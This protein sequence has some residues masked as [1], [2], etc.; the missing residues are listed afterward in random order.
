MTGSC[1]KCGDSIASWN[2]SGACTK[3]WPSVR[4]HNPRDTKRYDATWRAANQAKVTL[5]NCREHARQYGVP[6]SLTEA[7]IAPIP[8]KCASC[9]VIMIRGGP[10]RTQPSLDRM[11]PTDG[12]ISGNV[13]WICRRCNQV[14]NNATVAELRIVLAYMERHPKCAF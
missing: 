9:S 11:I 2:K 13:A 1:F 8:D 12:Y 10:W 14:K 4:V 3:C 7:D 6:F 5:R